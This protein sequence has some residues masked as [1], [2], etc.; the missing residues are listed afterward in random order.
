MYKVGDLVWVETDKEWY[1]DDVYMGPAIVMENL[2]TY[3]NYDHKVFLK[4]SKKLCGFDMWA[5]PKKY[6]KTIKSGGK[7]EY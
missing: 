1:H 6:I 5:V 7:I 3:D 4:L 2:G